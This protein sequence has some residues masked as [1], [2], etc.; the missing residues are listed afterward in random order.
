[1]L[2]L[3]T[4]FGWAA[5][6]LFGFHPPQR[7]ALCRI[8][9]HEGVMKKLNL[10]AAC[11]LLTGATTVGA[12]SLEIRN[13]LASEEA[14]LASKAALTDKTCG[15]QLKTNIDAATFDADEFTQKSSVSWCAAALD[16]MENVCT[17]SAIGK[18]AIAK[19]V[20]SLTC[21]GAAQMS[22]ELSNGNLKYA[23]PFSSSSNQNMQSIKIYLEKH[24]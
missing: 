1:V 5:L 8:H 9:S 22:V 3:R 24:L 16:A 20:K 11:M 13:R 2:R 17:A 6:R 10:L 4:R 14:E 12:Q 18:D 15:T 7:L 19:S 21:S 23:F